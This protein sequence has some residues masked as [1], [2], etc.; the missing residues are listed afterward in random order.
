LSKAVLI[1]D[2]HFG[3]RSDSPMFAR[4]F[5]RFY[6]EVF[7]PYLDEH[8]EIEHLIHLGDLVDRRRHIN[9]VTANHMREV[10]IDRLVGGYSLHTHWIV[11][12]HDAPYKNHININAVRELL[13]IDII[14]EHNVY[15]SPRVVDIGGHTCLIVPWICPDNQEET[16]RW[17]EAS[18]ARYVFGHLEL[19][20]FEMY[21]GSVQQHGFDPNLFD[22]FDWVFSGHYHH[23]SQKG[24]IHYLGAPYEMVWSDYDDPRGFHVL[25][26]NNNKLEFIQ[27]PHR[28]FYRVDC[29]GNSSIIEPALMADKVVKITPGADMKR[30]MFDYYV[31]QLNDVGAHVQVVENH[32]V[33]IDTVKD[34]IDGDGIENA[35]TLSILLNSLDHL[36]IDGEKKEWLNVVLSDLYKEASTVLI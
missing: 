23:K 8:P 13:P 11:G 1:T 3:A 12:N 29:A 35:D 16:M 17:L 4:Y 22:K 26:L 24:N 21:R 6:D 7:F 36:D 34:M 9:F 33:D 15:S 28:M 30:D 31:Q 5:Q 27:N 14:Q 2:T 20:G 18:R 25:D 19:S 32:A 10:F